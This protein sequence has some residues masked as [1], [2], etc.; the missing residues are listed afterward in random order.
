L[1]ELSLPSVR[2][3]L[4]AARACDASSDYDGRK[5]LTCSGSIVYALQDEGRRM[6]PRAVYS[7]DWG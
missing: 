1:V 7:P 4:I 3:H 6:S 5:S 2:L